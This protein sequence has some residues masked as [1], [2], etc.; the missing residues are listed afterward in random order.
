MNVT[1]NDVAEAVRLR[2]SADHI[3]LRFRPGSG[4]HPAA[5]AWLAE[6]EERLR[7]ALRNVEVGA[8]PDTTATDRLV[9]RWAERRR[10]RGP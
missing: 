2:A 6:V 5:Q 9:A 4:H 8:L 7:Q 10:K 3:R 1:T